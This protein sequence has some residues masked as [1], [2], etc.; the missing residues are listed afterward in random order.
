[1]KYFICIFIIFAFACSD[2]EPTVQS[3]VSQDQNTAL[4]M[5]SDK[6]NDVSNDPS[7]LP[8]FPDPNREGSKACENS[9]D[10][11]RFEYCNS[12]GGCTFGRGCGLFGK[13]PQFGGE[14]RGCIIDEFGIGDLTGAECESDDVCPSDMPYCYLRACQTQPRCKVAADCDSTQFC[15]F[16]TWCATLPPCQSDDDCLRG[17]CGEN[18]I[19]DY[20][21]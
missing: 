6:M 8:S 16:E 19:C 2:S 17:S 7:G 13:P 3:D 21:A 14:D 18:N 20:D 11:K 4:D 10:C 1:M 12:I 9:L 5:R 15:D